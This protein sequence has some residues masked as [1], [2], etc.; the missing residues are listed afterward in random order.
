MSLSTMD[1]LYFGSLGRRLQKFQSHEINRFD[2]LNIPKRHASV[3]SLYRFLPSRQG[4]PTRRFVFSPPTFG[5]TVGTGGDEYPRVDYPTVERYL[6]EQEWFDDSQL[7]QFFIKRANREGDRHSGQVGYP[8]GHCDSG[9]TCLEAAIRETKEEV[10]LDLNDGQRF[11]YIGV[12]PEMYLYKNHEKKYLFLKNYVFLSLDPNGNHMDLD[13]KEIEGFKWVPFSDMFLSKRPSPFTSV[14][15]KTYF[16]DALPKKLSWE[17][18]AMPINDAKP[19]FLPFDELQY[20]KYL[21]QAFT[22]WG[23]TL[24]LNRSKLVMVQD[25][26]PDEISHVLAEFQKVLNKNPLVNRTLYNLWG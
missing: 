24:R 6:G 15:W 18:P 22:L 17:T 13:P 10:G 16:S 7:Q 19:N 5:A 20:N 1:K 11:A 25:A 2:H 3:V 9:E 8:G 23:L 21:N 12:M 4:E 14:T 26:I